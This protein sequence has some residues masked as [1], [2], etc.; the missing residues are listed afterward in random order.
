MAGEIG[1]RKISRMERATSAVLRFALGAGATT[2]T[3]VA[4]FQ[5]TL[6]VNVIIGVCGAFAALVFFW[7]SYNAWTTTQLKVVPLAASSARTP[8]R[9]WMFEDDSPRDRRAWRGVV[10]KVI[11]WGAVLTYGIWG[12]WYLP[13]SSSALFDESNWLDVVAPAG[14]VV[15]FIFVAPAAIAEAWSVMVTHSTVEEAVKQR[16]KA[17]EVTAWTLVVALGIVAVAIGI[18]VLLML[19]ASVRHEVIDGILI[20]GIVLFVVWV[21][22]DFITSFSRMLDAREARLNERID[23]LQREIERINDVSHKNEDDDDY[24]DGIY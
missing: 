10:W 23:Q 6:P 9:L 2:A 18:A 17:W 8:Q 24:D 22:R 1:Y 12:L 5:A 4:A 11:F 7:G 16:D 13:P 3:A 21:I 20:V 14:A 19:R 15:S